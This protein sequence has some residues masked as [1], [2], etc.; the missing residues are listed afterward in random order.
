M[1]APTFFVASPFVDINSG[2][3]THS[4]LLH[5]HPFRGHRERQLVRLQGSLEVM[6]LDSEYK[7]AGR[8]NGS[9]K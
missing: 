1:N 6:H 5:Q 9:H 7:H 3:H 2:A 4:R 8:A